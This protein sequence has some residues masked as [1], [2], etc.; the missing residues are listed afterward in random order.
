MKIA[1]AMR[2]MTWLLA[3][4]LATSLTATAC[5]ADDVADELAGE[6][7][8]DVTGKSDSTGTFNY[9]QLQLEP[10]VAAE[11][12][13]FI[14]SRPNRSTIACGSSSSA[15]TCFVRAVDWSGTHL[16]EELG[17]ELEERLRGGEAILLRGETA[18]EQ[19][20]TRAH[21]LA[22]VAGVELREGASFAD[23]AASQPMVTI[24]ADNGPDCLYAKLDVSQVSVGSATVAMTP[25]LA[26]TIGL[27]DV[28]VTASSEYAVS[29]VNGV[30]PVTMHANHV[31]LTGTLGGSLSAT[32]TG[33]V[34]NDSG[35]PSVVVDML[36]LRE[37]NAAS[38]IERTAGVLLLPLAAPE[39]TK[40]LQ[41]SAT[42]VWVPSSGEAVDSSDDTFVL[43]TKQATRIKERRVN[44]TRTATIDLISLSASNAPADELDVATDALESGDDLII[45]GP[46]FTKSGKRGRRATQFWTRLVE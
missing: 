10:S 26:V 28:V 41:L 2:T 14:T 9:F 37:R 36:A 35:M 3:A 40:Q 32:L 34:V 39:T 16:P 19:P 15:P 21:R 42:E 31:D 44:S 4:G 11:T 29:C 25:E 7:D 6:G 43:V 13:G 38:T 45:A 30:S 5:T 24:G 23:L 17:V 33:L 22:T 20:A 18:P 46:R 12:A 8:D 1:A 27:D